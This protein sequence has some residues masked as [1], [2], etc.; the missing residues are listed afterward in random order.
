[1]LA[2]RYA[3]GTMT[4]SWMTVRACNERYSLAAFPVSPAH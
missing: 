3:D 4:S 1:M 2:R